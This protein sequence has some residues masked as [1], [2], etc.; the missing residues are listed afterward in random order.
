[1][2]PS[3]VLGVKSAVQ[4]S[5]FLNRLPIVKKF[6]K[7]GE[8]ESYEGITVEYIRGRKPVLTV[9]E[10]GVSREEVQ[11]ADYDSLE[12]LHALFADKGFHKKGEV[13]A[14]E[15]SGEINVAVESKVGDALKTSS[16][17][18]KERLEKSSK[19]SS[20]SLGSQGEVIPIK[21]NEDGALESAPVHTVGYLTGATIV[22]VVIYR[23]AASK[24]K[25]ARNVQ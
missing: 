23:V 11:L 21:A 7:G 24:K 4:V 20:V 1:M 9:Y 6:I 25:A 17:E 18:V 14:A 19:E 16:Q 10:D 22:G 15:K 2:Q 13:L 5:H 3:G 12:A 8:A